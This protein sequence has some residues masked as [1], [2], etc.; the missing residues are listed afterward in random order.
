VVLIGGPPRLIVP[1]GMDQTRDARAG[2]YAPTREES[3]HDLIIIKPAE[4]PV[5]GV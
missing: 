1:E 5:A 2:R 4:M 3:R